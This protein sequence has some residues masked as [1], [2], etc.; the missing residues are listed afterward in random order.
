ME[1]MKRF[2]EGMIRQTREDMEYQEKTAPEDPW[3]RFLEGKMHAFRLVR[4]YLDRRQSQE[5]L[6]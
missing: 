1:D 3:N 5:N 6:H 2:L 4:E